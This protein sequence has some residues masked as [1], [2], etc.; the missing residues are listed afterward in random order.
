MFDYDLYK[1]IEPAG[2]IYMAEAE[3]GKKTCLYQEP[4]KPGGIRSVTIT[5]AT[6]EERCALLE[7]VQATKG[8][9]WGIEP[10]PGPGSK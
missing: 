3:N 7:A 10:T 6:K 8:V 9:C 1:Q 2:V 4:M 5:V